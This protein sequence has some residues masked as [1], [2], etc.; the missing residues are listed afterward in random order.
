MMLVRYEIWQSS[1]ISPQVRLVYDQKQ[2]HL[3]AFQLLPALSLVMSLN[4][5]LF[6][7]LRK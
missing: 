1:N 6:W 2:M 4:M 3:F 7:K 5:V